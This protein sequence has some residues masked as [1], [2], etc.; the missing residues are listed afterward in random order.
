MCGSEVPVVIIKRH[1]PCPP[2]VGKARYQHCRSLTRGSVNE[3]G[4][5]RRGKVWRKFESLRLLT[6]A[7]VLDFVSRN[8]LR[9]SCDVDG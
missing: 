2:A 6:R 9:F 5:E 8:I 3:A 1:V 7:A 4:F